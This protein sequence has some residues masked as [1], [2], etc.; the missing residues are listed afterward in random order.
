MFIA[1]Q[2]T[3]AKIWKQPQCIL[4]YEQEKKITVEYSSI[5]IIFCLLQSYR[6]IWKT[7]SWMKWARHKM[8]NTSWSWIVK[9]YLI[10]KYNGDYQMLGWLGMEKRC[11]SN[12]SYLQIDSKNKFKRAI[13]EYKCM[14]TTVDD[15]FLKM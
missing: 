10:I 12:H 4:M 9:V 1:V 3:T 13:L 5:K 11:C 6:W 15:I 7:L 8:T 14:V 2:L